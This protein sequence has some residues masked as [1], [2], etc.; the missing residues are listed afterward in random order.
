IDW[1]TGARGP[2]RA[3]VGSQGSRNVISTASARP[4]AGGP[5]RIAAAVGLPASTVHRVLRRLG[6][7]E[8]HREPVPI[9]R[10]EHAVAGGL[11]HVDTKKLGR[12][13]GGPG[14]PGDRGP[15]GSEGRG[16]LGRPPR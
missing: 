8:H 13:V 14:H 3:R 9:V 1:W 16:R 11:L 12:I 10:Y 2:I 7:L 6:L 15:P 5:D 4:P